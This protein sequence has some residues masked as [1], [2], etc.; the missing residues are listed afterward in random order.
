MTVGRLLQ[1]GT[2][3]KQVASGFPRRTRSGRHPVPELSFATESV[4]NR[5]AQFAIRIEPDTKTGAVRHRHAS[6]RRYRLIQ[7]QRSEHRNHDVRFGCHHQ[8]FRKRA[9]MARDHKM[10]TVDA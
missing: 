8:V 5:A 10:V 1:Q 7:Q 6:V 3:F 2:P 4:L 9:V